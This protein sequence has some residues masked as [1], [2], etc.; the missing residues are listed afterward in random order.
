MRPN[1]S[2]FL[3]ALSLLPLPSL[4]EQTAITRVYSQI[5]AYGVPDGFVPAFEDTQPGF[6]IQEAVPRGQSLQDW[7]QMLTMT[8]AEGQATT[9]PEALAQ[10][11]AQGFAAACPDSVSAVAL[12]APA[13][14]GARAS[15][16]AHVA[17]GNA[18]GR[19][20]ELMLFVFAGAQDLY[21]VQWAERSAARATPITLDPGVWMPR[22]DRLVSSIRVCDPVPG[23]AP[24]F[25]SCN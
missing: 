8:G 23:E 9:A 1:L 11:I 14:P 6:Y 21:T 7:T 15:F 24:P 18:G 16:A 10:Q 22:Y 4:A 20:E 13:I 12:P 25:A 2:L 5:V 3:V 17:C 19:A